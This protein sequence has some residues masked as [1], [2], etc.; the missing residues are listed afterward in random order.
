[1]LLTQIAVNL[2]AIGVVAAIWV[3]PGFVGTFCL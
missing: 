3:K 1:M 2:T